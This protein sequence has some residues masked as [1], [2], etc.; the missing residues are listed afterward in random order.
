MRLLSF[1]FIISFSF[2]EASI[3]QS[4][5]LENLLN[6]EI[7]VEKLTGR[8]ESYEINFSGW[9]GALKFDLDERK[10]YIAEFTTM[11]EK[12]SVVLGVY[13]ITHFT[14]YSKSIDFACRDHQTGI[15]WRG[16][17]WLLDNSLKP[18]VEIVQKNSS[19]KWVNLSYYG[20]RFMR[21]NN[22]NNIRLGI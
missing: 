3:P 16:K 9:V 18:M 15:E 21:E 10:I 2:F 17:I 4:T 20:E 13:S 11:E 14:K 6:L 7:A 19:R 5:L 1:I 8:G 22:F 12:I